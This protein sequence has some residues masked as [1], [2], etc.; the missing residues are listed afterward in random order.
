MD[1]YNAINITSRLLLYLF[2][3]ILHYWII[4]TAE[5]VL[6]RMVTTSNALLRFTLIS[7]LNCVP[8]L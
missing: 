5:H 1:G 7:I 3:N 6:T 2:V 4:F 8:S